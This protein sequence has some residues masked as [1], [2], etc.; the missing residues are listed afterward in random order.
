LYSCQRRETQASSP[1]SAVPPIPAAFKT[2]EEEQPALPAVARVNTKTAR[3]RS[4]PKAN[5]KPVSL[6][7]AQHELLE[8]PCVG[9]GWLAACSA[10][11]LR[12]SFG[13]RQLAHLFQIQSHDL[14]R[15]HDKTPRRLPAI[16]RENLFKRFEIGHL[17]TFES[18]EHRAI[19]L[20]PNDRMS[21]IRQ[22]GA[23]AILTP[24]LDSFGESVGVAYGE[25]NY[26]TELDRCSIDQDCGRC[27]TVPE[28]NRSVCES[29]Y[30][31]L[32]REHDDDP[33][34][35]QRRPIGQ[36]QP[37]DAPHTG[38]SV[39]RNVRLK[40]LAYL[41]ISVPPQSSQFLSVFGLGGGR[42][43]S[44]TPPRMSES[45]KQLHSPWP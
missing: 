7:L 44:E 1:T 37:R 28:L 41:S 38:M 15:T 5:T 35:E 29:G 31:D 23:G 32:V 14:L 22:I 11:S 26:P 6:R 18:L 8:K 25:I 9:V 39:S 40:I 17:K 24:P 42:L 10:H 19:D 27:R 20:R 33:P 16:F 45:Q 12:T 13:Q 2:A 4:M 3:M 21:V 36:L 30:L 34:I 43:S